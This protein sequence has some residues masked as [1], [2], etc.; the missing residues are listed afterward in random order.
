MNLDWIFGQYYSIHNDILIIMKCHLQ[1]VF[2]QWCFPSKITKSLF[3][4][5]DVS[6][7]GLLKE[8]LAVFRYHSGS[9]FFCF[10]RHQKS[11]FSLYFAHKKSIERRWELYMGH[12]AEQKPKLSVG[13]SLGQTVSSCH[14]TSWLV[15][16]TCNLNQN[17]LLWHLHKSFGHFSEDKTR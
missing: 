7:S 8:N 6:K 12:Q 4:K 3:Q 5:L 16:H 11:Y 14:A 15:Q 10:S 1:N 9:I 17:S 2:L 13:S